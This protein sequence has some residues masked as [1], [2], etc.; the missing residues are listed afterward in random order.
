[1][2]AAILPLVTF[3]LLAWAGRPASAQDVI[4][5]PP[6]EK[7]GEKQGEKVPPPPPLAPLEPGCDHGHPGV[8][9]LWMERQV[10]IQVLTPREV[11]V[12]Q[13]RPTLVV[14]FKP[15]KREIT[16]MVL[17]PREVTREIPFTTMKPCV[18]VCPETGHCATV[19]K[20]CTEMRLVKDVVFYS[21]PVKRTIVVPVPFVKEVEEVVP[22]RTIILE[23]KTELQR[24][25]GAISVPTPP[26]PQTRWMLG[27]QGCPEE[28]PLGCPAGTPGCP[29]QPGHP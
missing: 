11:V 25:P 23:Y 10:P 4:P 15:E 3:G 22:T 8:K 18:E 1:M 16:E 9:I 24:R 13:K 12:P 26:E 2:K 14:E 28:A 7:Q 19:M 6:Q 17:K 27:P 5:P 21:A 29:A 20:P